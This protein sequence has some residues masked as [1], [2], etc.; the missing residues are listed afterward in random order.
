[1]V[2]ELSNMDEP[3]GA[4][5]SQKVAILFADVVGFTGLAESQP[6]EKVL[7]LLREVL[8]LMATRV[9]QHALFQHEGTLDKHL[10]D[11]IMATFG[12][13][14]TDGRE[15]ENALACA[16]GML[17]DMTVLNKLRE[18]RGEP[19]I[20]LGIGVHFGPVVLGDVGDEHRLEVAVVGDA[21]NVASRFERLT[22]ELGVALVASGEL[23]TALGEGRQALVE[24]LVHA[25]PQLLRG[26]EKP[27]P[28]WTL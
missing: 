9:F 26:R 19:P 6:P 21:V 5:R 14:R 20:S 24:G 7:A 10:G 4:A 18:A 15:A 3:L 23:V 17:E 25:A 16:R 12:T 1:M 13:P 11:G 8:K 28:V 22:R 27:V 2:E